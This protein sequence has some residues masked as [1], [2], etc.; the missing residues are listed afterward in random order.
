MENRPNRTARRRRPMSV[1]NPWVILG[2][3]VI[4]CILTT[5]S[6]GI[7]T[8]SSRGRNAGAPS[9][10]VLAVIPAATITP[11]GES[12]Q[13]E[14]P[15]SAEQT[16]PSPPPGE[17]AVGAYVQVTGTGGDGLRMRD[18]PG[19]DGKILFVASESEVFEVAKGSVEM[20]GY[21]WWRLVGPF[22][23]TRQGWAVANYLEVVQKP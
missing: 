11:T 6:L 20:D 17:L 3:L 10:A 1:I 15:G 2:A 12:A 9:T 4:A 7:Y 13:G 5:I 8:L 18:K 21:S 16:P 23:D 22:D 14:V 19:L